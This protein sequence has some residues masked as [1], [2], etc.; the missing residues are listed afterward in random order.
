MANSSDIVDIL[1]KDLALTQADV[2]QIE[3][4]LATMPIDEAREWRLR[5]WE[6][7]GLVV[8]NPEYR[9]DAKLPVED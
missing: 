8:S 6:G 3:S 2:Q 7:V 1:G 4:I 9:G 5:A